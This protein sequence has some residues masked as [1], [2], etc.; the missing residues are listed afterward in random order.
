VFILDFAATFISGRNPW[1]RLPVEFIGIVIYNFC[2]MLSNETGY[3]LWR[4]SNG[5]N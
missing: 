3:A 4:K 1:G 5:K 2:T